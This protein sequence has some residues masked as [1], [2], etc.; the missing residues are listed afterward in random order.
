M[1][2][3]RK[4]LEPSQAEGMRPRIAEPHRCVPGEFFSAVGHGE[5]NAGER[6]GS[7]EAGD[8][9]LLG[10]RAVQLYPGERREFSAPESSRHP[11]ARRAAL[12]GRCR[13]P[14]GASAHHRRRRQ[15]PGTGTSLRCRAG[16]GLIRVRDPEHRLCV[17]AMLGQPGHDLFRRGCGDQHLVPAHG[18]AAVPRAR[19]SPG[20]VQPGDRAPG[21]GAQLR[22][23]EASRTRRPGAAD[24]GC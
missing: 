5:V 19:T 12:P 3:C 22:A 2:W 10:R 9:E 1:K 4:T 11:S 24:R 8:E 16:D 6:P 14:A 20:E 23:P 13:R 7:F 18:G 17:L 21:R 15:A